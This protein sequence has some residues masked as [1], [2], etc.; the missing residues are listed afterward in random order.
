MVK[1]QDQIRFIIINIY[2]HYY[3]FIYLLL[4]FIIT[5]ITI[6]IYYLLYII[7]YLLFIIYISYLL[8]KKKIIHFH[9]KYIIIMYFLCIFIYK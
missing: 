8:L 9:I 1:G 6:I 3:S 7:Y 2:Y 4:L 5:I